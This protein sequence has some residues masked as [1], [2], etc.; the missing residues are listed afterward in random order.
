MQVYEICKSYV[1]IYILQ[2][3]KFFGVRMQKLDQR[4]CWHLKTSTLP[5][6]FRSPNSLFEI[7]L[8]S[9]TDIWMKISEAEYYQ[10]ILSTLNGS[11]PVGRSEHMS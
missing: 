2:C 7:V 5:A 11:F 9:A 4:V 8:C 10:N 6:V 1:F 3:L